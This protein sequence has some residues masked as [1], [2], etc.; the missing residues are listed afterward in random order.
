MRWLRGKP[1]F[2]RAFALVSRHPTASCCS[3]AT[4]TGC[5]SPAAWLPVLPVS[6]RKIPVA[7]L[8]VGSAVGGPVQRI[9]Y[10]F[11]L[12]AESLVGAALAK[13]QRVL[14]ALAGGVVFGIAAYLASHY[15]ARHQGE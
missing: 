10:A 9:G 2:D 11:G 7:Q 1:G 5:G 3:T 4:P 8:R 13:H 14:I 15:G 6:P 12:A